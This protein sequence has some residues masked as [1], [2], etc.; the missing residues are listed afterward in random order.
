MFIKMDDASAL[1]F[2]VHKLNQNIL[3]T[4]AAVA[5]FL[6]SFVVVCALAI[7]V[8]LYSDSG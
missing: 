3:D 6:T 4:V 2:V 1:P 5:H 8:Y 7:V